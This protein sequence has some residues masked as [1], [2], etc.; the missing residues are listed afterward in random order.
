MS[1]H[2][3][4]FPCFFFSRIIG[5][6][7]HSGFNLQNVALPLICVMPLVQLLFLG[8]FSSSTFRYAAVLG[9]NKLFKIISVNN[10]TALGFYSSTTTPLN[11]N[12]V[13]FESTTRAGLN[14][15]LPHFV[16]SSACFVW[17]SW[18]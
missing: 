5:A 8:R 11:W 14:K 2:R 10:F 17:I 15:S 6:S 9:H 13:H 18:I 16:S 7:H 1:Y 3:L 4:P 12:V